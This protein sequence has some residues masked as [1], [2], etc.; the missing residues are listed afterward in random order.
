[1][2][3]LSQWDEI[4]AK[5]D[6]YVR[7]AD[8]LM[9]IREL[10]GKDPAKYKVREYFEQRLLEGKVALAESGPN[11]D[12]QRKAVDTVVIHHTSNDQ[13]YTLPKMNAVQLLNV[14]IPYYLDPKVLNERSLKHQPV[15]SNHFHEGKQVFYAYHWF[16]HQ[17][18]SIQRL[19]DDEKIG[20]HAGNWDINCR[21]VGICL[22]DDYS[23]KDPDRETLRRVARIIKEN[24]S[25]IPASNIVGHRQV[26]Q[27]T[28][29]PGNN[30]EN[31]WKQELIE[32]LR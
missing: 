5:P 19:L 18:G 13:A 24:Y 30:F 21:S 15:W 25:H 12:E 27:K 23:N 3:D 16:V 26:N 4:I 11:L 9:L 14:Y 8:D 28:T 32:L 10:P 2:I 31:G 29:C 17:D 1:M 20:W 22:D 7:L 6:W